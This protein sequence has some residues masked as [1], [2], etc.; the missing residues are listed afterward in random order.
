M[1]TQDQLSRQH[2]PCHN[3]APRLQSLFPSG[4]GSRHQ[5]T[6]LHNSICMEL[7][8]TEQRERQWQR[9]YRRRPTA[10]ETQ[11]KSDRDRSTPISGNSL[12]MHGFPG[13]QFPVKFGCQP[14]KLELCPLAHTYPA[15]YVSVHC[16][17]L[18]VYKESQVAY[19]AIRVRVSQGLV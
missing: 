10:L 18:G 13:C 7:M 12:R 8:T 4:V 19:R 9:A 17:Y 6:W 2:P 5:P 3:L 11:E 1:E 16:R 15:N 14:I